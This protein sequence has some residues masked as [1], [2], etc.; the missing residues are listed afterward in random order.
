[1]AILLSFLFGVGSVGYASTPA[2]Q[3]I[4]GAAVVTGVLDADPG[5]MSKEIRGDAQVWLSVGQIL[6]YQVEVPQSGSFEFHV[7]PGKY[8]LSAT[9]SKGCLATKEF[10]VS[11][12]Q[13]ANMNLR[14]AVKPVSTK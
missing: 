10:K 12:Q 4:Q 5:C 8:E 7:L 11:A 2:I 3:P 13:V 9:T 14:L 1:M 6:L